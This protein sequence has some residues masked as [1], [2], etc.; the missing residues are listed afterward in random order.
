[1]NL[2]AFKLGRKTELCLGE[3]ESIFGIKNL[4]ENNAEFA[5]FKLNLEDT[6]AQN[7]QN[8]LGGTIKIIKIFDSS[9]RLEESISSI[10][11]K[12]FK[13]RSG[14]IPFAIS[15]LNF[16]NPKEINIK[17]LLNFS[18]KFLKSLGLNSRFVNKDFSSAESATIFKARIIE[19]GI[20]INI[21]KGNSNIYM[22]ETLAVQDL[23]S[24]SKRDFDKPR[25]D[26][27][28]GMLPPKL[29]QIMINLAGTDTKTIYDPFCGTGTILTEG[30]LMDK[31]VIGTDIEQKMIDFS[32]ENLHWIKREMKDKI[33]ETSRF[34]LFVK[35]SRFLNKTDFPEKIDAVITESYLGKPISS[36]PSKEER[37]KT[38]R[39]L[40]NLN[41]NWL[42]SVNK[43][44][45]KNCPIVTCIPAF[46][47]GQT[48]EFFPHFE[49]IAKQ[50]GYK[51][52]HSFIYDRPDQI[53]AREIK[54][55][56]KSQSKTQYH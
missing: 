21:I 32:R 42:I 23:D 4:I 46:K 44:T 26:M 49:E 38:F 14:K 33:K 25:R 16:T 22:G 24:Y 43:I 39:E 41:L 28:T 40:A 12:T 7:L 17:H 19:K 34:R 6:E 30:L 29:A 1:M 56:E 36:L 52:S 9:G 54:V 8:R 50:A 20:D 37:E 18:K 10:L 3:L 55:L 5:I 15:L 53:V 35:D 47:T 48:F 45:E 11:K 31:N 2:F 13:D 27:A 51:I